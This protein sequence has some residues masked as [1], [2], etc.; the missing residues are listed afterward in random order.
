M[1]AKRVRVL[2]APYLVLNLIAAS[3]G[4]PDESPREAAEQVRPAPA[5][6]PTSELVVGK[7]RMIKEEPADGKGGFFEQKRRLLELRADGTYHAENYIEA[8]DQTWKLKG[9]VLV[10]VRK[11]GEVAQIEVERVDERS[12]VLIEDLP[13]I[14]LRDGP[15]RKVRNTYRR[16]SES[17]LGPMLGAKVVTSAPKAGSYAAAYRYGMNKYPTM[18]INIS[19]SING[20]ARLELKPDGS[21]EG[22]VGVVAG[23]RF[24]ESKYSSPDGKHHS[25]DEDEYWLAG[26]RGTWEKR[27]DRALVR[28][29]RFWRD[30]CDTSRGEGDSMGPI[31][32]ECRTIAPNER[33]PVAT[34]ACRV[35]KSLRLLEEIAINPADT[36]RSG[37]YTLQVEPR[38]HT[39]PDTGRPWWLFGAAPGLKI[40]SEDDRHADQPVV[41]FTKGEVS[42]VEARYKRREPRPEQ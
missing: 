8:F 32:L 26:F 38:G 35:E 9:D 7:W 41:T 16:V 5:Q 22:C 12:L 25:R 19:K 34:L 40:E 2:L 4:G 18:E 15:P 42:I 3:C 13:E 10:L 37:P 6:R 1:K 17:E 28:I 24:S 27:E 20:S 23:R 11:P 39:S 36:E 30:A 33:L 14:Y 31:E 21:V 29:G